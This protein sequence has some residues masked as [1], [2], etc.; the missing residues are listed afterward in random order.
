MINVKQEI[1]FILPVQTF[2]KLQ[3]LLNCSR[4]SYKNEYSDTY[5]MIHA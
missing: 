1:E 4:P 3:N 2:Q 5:L